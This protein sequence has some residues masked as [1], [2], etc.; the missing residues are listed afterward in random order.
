MEEKKPLKKATEPTHKQLLRDPDIEPTG[1]V[2]AQA[3]G[4]ANDAYKKFVRKLGSL[5][6]QLVWRYYT[7]GKAWLA[8]GLY[9]WIGTRG[10]QKEVTVFWLSIWEGFFKVTVY[11]PE[12]SRSELSQLPLT[13]EI[14][15]MIADAQPMGKRLNFFY[16]VFD[17]RSNEMFDAIFGLLEF[18][19]SI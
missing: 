11:I 13:E 8:K 3:L 16:L 1:D 4:E 2:L 12:K 6:I 18:R 9:Q 10:G 15:R 5:D 14:K 17:L 19:K 7:D